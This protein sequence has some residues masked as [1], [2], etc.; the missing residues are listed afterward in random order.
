MPDAYIGEAVL[1]V[2]FD[3]GYRINQSLNAVNCIYKSYFC[4][5]INTCMELR[6]LKYFVKVA[7]M[8]SFSK[9]SKALFITQSTLSQQIKQLEDE[10]DMALFFRNNHKVALTEA[11]STF[12]DGAKKLLA[13]ADD[14]KARLMDLAMG[15]SG[16]LNIGVTYSFGSILTESV[17]AFKKEFPDVVLNICYKNVIELMELV[18][19][20]ELDFAL[21]FRSSEKYDNVESHILFDNKLCIIVREGHP[22][23]RKDFVRLADLEE[24]EMVLPSHG[25]QARSTFDEIIQERNLTLKVAM[26]ANEVNAILNILRKSNYVTVLSETVILEHEGLVTIDIDDAECSMEGCLHFCANRYR[27]RSTE[28]FIRLL[29]DTKALRRSRLWL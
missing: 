12:L 21:S 11:G 19:E 25:L 22:L 20:G 18:S 5:I 7:E 6:Q 3:C 9:A 2:I 17:L 16:V 4:R 15:R 28:E 26:E 8:L 10:L 27:K 14:N 29:S 1:I 13:E 23:L 24:Y